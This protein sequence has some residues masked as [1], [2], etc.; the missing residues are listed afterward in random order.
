M[1]GRIDL[2]YRTCKVGYVW[3]RGQDVLLVDRIDT[4]DRM[5]GYRMVLCT[6]VDRGSRMYARMSV[7]AR[8]KSTPSTLPELNSHTTLAMAHG[9]WRMAHGAWRTA[10]G[11]WR[12]AHGAWC[13]AHGAWCMAHSARR[14]AHSARRM[15]HGAW[16]M[17]HGVWRT[18]HSA[19]RMAHGARR[20]AHDAC[21]VHDS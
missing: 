20:M 19:Q 12:M 3:Q 1:H 17:A 21:M 5:D 10:H 7:S 9:A 15:A 16:R 14:T 8:A 13:M 6:V 11:A 4:I 2:M 18:A